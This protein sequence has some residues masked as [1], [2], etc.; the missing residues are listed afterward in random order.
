MFL[1]YSYLYGDNYQGTPGGEL[2]SFAYICRHKC[3]FSYY[4]YC[5]VSYFSTDNYLSNGTDATEELSSYRFS[6]Y[7]P[8][9]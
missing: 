6:F 4:Y 9:S 5:D 8:I 3:C 1:I 2:A 7:C